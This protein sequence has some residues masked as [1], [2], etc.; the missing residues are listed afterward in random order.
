MQG[1]PQPLISEG[2]FIYACP[3]CGWR[4]QIYV[5]RPRSITDIDEED[6]CDVCK[7]DIVIERGHPRLFRQ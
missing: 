6:R 3:A 7:R 1:P 4:L 5:E 2:Q